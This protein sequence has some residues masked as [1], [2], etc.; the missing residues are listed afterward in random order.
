MFK[1]EGVQGRSWSQTLELLY[2]LVSKELKV[3]YKNTFLGYLWALANPLA[4]TLVYYVA[5]KIVMRVE[6]EDFALYLVVGLFPWTWMASTLMHSAVAYRNNASLIKKVRLQPSVLPLS[7]ALQEMVHFFFALPILIGFVIL[8]KQTVHLSWALLIPLMALIQLAMI[9]PIG[10]ILANANV[11]VRDV[12]YLVGVSLSMLFFL[13][14][15]VYPTSMLPEEL[16]IYFM[17]NPFFPMIESWRE[18]IYHGSL[19][20]P[21][22]FQ[23]VGYAVVF[24][25]IGV[26]VHKKL[27]HRIAELL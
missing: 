9:Y 11:F 13:T 17:V 8:T 23:C 21:L 25:G 24:A 12:E 10:V 7:S 19:D 14:P 26:V 18:I 22:F 2:L 3:R 27:G 1:V 16:R 5:F 4:Y 6:M 20:L 15:I